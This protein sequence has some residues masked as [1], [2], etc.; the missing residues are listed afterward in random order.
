MDGDI[1][2]EVIEVE[3]EIQKCLELERRK[4]QEWLEKMKALTAEESARNEREIREDFERAIAEAERQAVSRAAV[5]VK[6]AEARAGR[7]RTLDERTLKSI[8]EK[9]VAKI[10]PG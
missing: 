2:S 4:A 9:H 10:L 5:V 3:K 7:L 1:L 8:V 6:D